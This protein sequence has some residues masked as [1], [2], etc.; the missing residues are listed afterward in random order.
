M[1]LIIVAGLLE[2]RRN[3]LRLELQGL[4]LSGMPCETCSFCDF[5]HRRT[6]AYIEQLLYMNLYPMAASMSIRDAITALSNMSG[7]KVSLKRIYC[8][9]FVLHEIH[10]DEDRKLNLDKFKKSIGL[11]FS[12]IRNLDKENQHS[13]H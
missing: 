12:I 11:S 7:P 5:P 10:N 4:A 6:V 2:E 9:H 1:S 13:E 3:A 8:T